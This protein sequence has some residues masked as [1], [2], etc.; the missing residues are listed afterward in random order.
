[1]AI[2]TGK[3]KGGLKY[4][5]FYFTINSNKS[6]KV[7]EIPEKELEHFK[8]ICEVIGNNITEFMI[9]RKNPG[10]RS[11]I[12][13]V[14]PLFKPEIGE[15]RGFAHC[16][17]YIKVEHSGIIQINAQKLKK[18]L[19]EAVPGAYI[20]QIKGMEDQSFKLE[21]YVTKSN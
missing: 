8:T 11:A 16:H 10:S 1:M 20:S 6:G 18:F 21:S 12:L 2:S 14:L 13:R 9:D 17:Y 3:H 15:N 7:A 4:S 19:R 5:G